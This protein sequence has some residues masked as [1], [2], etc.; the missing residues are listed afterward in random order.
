MNTGALRRVMVYGAVTLPIAITV[1]NIASVITFIVVVLNNGDLDPQVAFAVVSLF[2]IIRSPF[3]TFP[4]AITMISRILVAF[5]RLGLFFDLPTRPPRDVFPKAAPGEDSII[6]SHGKFAWELDSVG[7]EGEKVNQDG[8]AGQQDGTPGQQDGKPGEQDGKE[9]QMDGKPGLQ[10]GKAGQQEEQQSS[11]ANTSSDS[12]NDGSAVVLSNVNLNIR[13]G[14]LVAVCGI[15]GS[16]KSSL[17]SALLGEMTRVTGDV[18]VAGKV[19]YCAQEAFILNATVR[20]NITFGKPFER[21]L[22]DHVLH[23]CALTSDLV[24]LP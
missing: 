14:E 7:D 21:E 16:G 22:Y 12:T 8:K 24:L 1:P 9:V 13:S 5:R 17:C 3:V 2:V 6:V 23:V 19:A 4:L 20:E 18:R 10:D 11:E 15:V